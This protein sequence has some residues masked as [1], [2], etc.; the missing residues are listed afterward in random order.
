MVFDPSHPTIIN[1]IPTIMAYNGYMN[2][3]KMKGKLSFEGPY[4]SGKYG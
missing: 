4:L 2:H 1:G 3:K